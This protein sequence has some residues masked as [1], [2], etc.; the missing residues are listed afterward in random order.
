MADKAEKT[1]EPGGTFRDCDDCPEMMVLPAGTFTMGSP[2]SEKERNDDEGPQHK[3]TIPRPFAVG[4]FEVTFAEWDACV[5]GSG[6]N[7]YRPNDE[8]WGRG[9]SPVINVSWDDAKAYVEWLAKTTGENYRLLSEAEWE[10]AARAGTTTPFAT[11][12]TITTDQ[13]NFDGNATYNG[14]R[15]G[16]YR[17]KTTPVATF[18][19][20]SFG[21]HDL[22]G[23]VW[24][25]VEDCYND[26]YLEAPTDGTARTNEDCGLRVLRG[27]SFGKEPR[28]L[29]SA[30][31]VWF[32]PS[33]R[34]DAIG[35]R[36]A[37]TLKP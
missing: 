15:R 22:H 27:G 14:S 21:L 33:Y 35:L 9:E 10:Y 5:A 2:A 36:V 11:G 20:N 1:Y 32:D 30:Y 19:A 24:E 6:C 23:N 13:A 18:D 28:L 17:G 7:G 29:R 4:K 34:H 26:S 31:R 37:R 8:G 12:E 3:V 25:W 16:K